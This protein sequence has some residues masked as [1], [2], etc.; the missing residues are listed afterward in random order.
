MYDRRDTDYGR[1]AR[2]NSSNNNN[3]NNNKRKEKQ[4]Q[5]QQNNKTAQQKQGNDDANGDEAGEQK[6]AKEVQP[7][8]INDGKGMHPTSLMGWA[9]QKMLEA[10]AIPVSRCYNAGQ[11]ASPSVVPAHAVTPGVCAPKI[12]GQRWQ[13]PGFQRKSGRRQARRRRATAPRNRNPRAE[14]SEPPNTQADQGPLV[15][16]SAQN[17]FRVACVQ[18][19]TSMLPSIADNF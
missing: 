6:R 16:H 7:V 17:N 13:Q 2:Q 10:R 8:T 19:R 9:A 15:T 1:K 3:N 5:Q 12:R 4:Q 14:R 11:S 18:E